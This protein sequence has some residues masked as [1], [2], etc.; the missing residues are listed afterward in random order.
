MS[1]NLSSKSGLWCNAFHSFKSFGSFCFLV[2]K[3][4]V[5]IRKTRMLCVFKSSEMSGARI[6]WQYT[7]ARGLS[8]R[9]FKTASNSET[10]SA[11]KMLLLCLEKPLFSTSC[12]ILMSVFF[13]KIFR[14]QVLHNFSK[15]FCVRVKA[16]AHN[17]VNIL[18]IVFSVSGG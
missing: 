13:G 10:E 11:R 18:V 17:R 9:N 3:E 14:E 5:S 2:E 6:Q 8:S 12:K 16:Q 15:I 4:S 1:K 7:R